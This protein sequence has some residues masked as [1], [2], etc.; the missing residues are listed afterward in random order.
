L[1]I[2]IFKLPTSTPLFQRCIS[3]H[4]SHVSALNLPIPKSVAG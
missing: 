4:H 2:N 3:S 1:H